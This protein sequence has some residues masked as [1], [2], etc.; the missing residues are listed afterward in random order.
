MDLS[1]TQRTAP[2]ESA[3]AGSRKLARMKEIFPLVPVLWAIFLLALHVAVIVRAILRPHRQPASR[4]AWVAVILALPILGLVAYLLLGETNIGRA[5]RQRAR[6]AWARLPELSA[7]PGWAASELRPQVL[8][9]HSHLF[10]VGHS[11]NG[12]EAVGANRASLMQD[13]N[14]AVDALVADMDAAQETIHVLF[15]IWLQDHNGLK[16]AEA[17]KRAAARGVTCRA[18]ADG[19]G[20]RVMI[21]SAHWREMKAAGVKLA[22]ALPIGNPVVRAWKGRIDL[23]NHRKIMIIDNRITYCGSQNCADPEFRVKA[24]YAPWVDIMLRLEV[25]VVAQCQLLFAADWLLN[26]GD[27]I[28]ASLQLKTERID[29]GFPPSFSPTALRIVVARLLSCLRHC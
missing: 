6:D 17:L 18:M 24:K 23:R 1:A 14:A 22:V 9:R 15:Y 10:Q 29:D 8:E 3:S 25:P 19:L 28:P 20:S 26:S 5:R 11:V 7:T 16:V 12:F 27:D 2:A 21:A 4:V 13:S